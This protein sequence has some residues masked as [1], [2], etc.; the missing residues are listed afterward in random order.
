MNGRED[1]GADVQAWPIL[2]RVPTLRRIASVVRRIRRV[3]AGR[4]AS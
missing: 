3:T 1:G 4:A 2:S